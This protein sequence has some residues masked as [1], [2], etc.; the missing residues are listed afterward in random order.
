MKKLLLSI[1]A[2]GLGCAIV[3]N[4]CKKKDDTKVTTPTTNTYTCSSCIA[5]PE[6]KAAND[7]VS[8]GIYKGVIV[9][10]TGTIKFD[11][12]N[13]D[14]T[15]K[16]YLVMDGVSTILTAKVA[17]NADSAYVSP[18]EGTLDG[19]PVSIT[20]RIDVNGGNPIVT[21]MNIPGHP[22]AGLTLSKETST[23]LIKCFEGTATNATTGKK[24]TF[25][26][27]LST[28]LK[29]WGAKVKE[30]GSTSVSEVNGSFDG[31]TLSFDDGKGANGTAKLSGDEI[32]DGKWTNTKPENG[33]WTAK[34]TL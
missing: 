14:N 27:I 34:R 1:I 19:Q 26:L 30:E 2:L 9:G 20:L 3:L 5:T 25:D 21:A 16:A 12:M 32:V 22:N 11:I 4:A 24:A 18:F 15:I 23:N 31:T 13:S 10:S 17:W 7:N 29:K 28:S 8:K 33:T 6:A